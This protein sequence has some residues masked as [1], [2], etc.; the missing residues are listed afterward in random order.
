MFKCD[1]IFCMKYL[2]KRFTIFVLAFFITAN[3][4]AEIGSAMYVKVSDLSVKDK[5]SVKAKT[6]LTVNYG[7]VVSVVMEKK[8]WVQIKVDDKVAGWVPASSLSERKVAAS[9]VSV[10]AKELALA[11]RGANSG[12]EK[13]FKETVGENFE[14]VDL[15]ESFGVS[16][17]KVLLFIEEGQLN[18]GEE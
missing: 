15:I 14:K 5:P 10:T 3:L 1:I 16:Q 12:F 7:N 4:F 11:G 18:G 8:G 6:V 17:E 13:V 9:K 2:I